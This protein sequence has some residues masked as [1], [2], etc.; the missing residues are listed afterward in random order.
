MKC[1]R[2]FIIGIVLNFL[3]S[4]P[5]YAQHYLGGLAGLSLADLDMSVHA[6]ARTAF[7]LGAMYDFDFSDRFALHIEAMYLQKGGSIDFPDPGPDAKL[8]SDYFELPFL[9]KISS[10][11]GDIRPYFEMGPSFGLL[12]ASSIEAEI[13]GETYSATIQ[14]ITSGLDVG[15]TAGGGIDYYL[16]N[17]KL[18]I[19]ARYTY[20]AN[21]MRVHGTA[22]L[23]GG[24]QSEIINFADDYYKNKCLQV[25][26]GISF[27]LNTD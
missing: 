12:L 19:Q 17:K 14:E 8:K 6:D 13:D 7:G 26:A 27:L 3:W 4:I 16:G 21:R 5:V 1:I 11:G 18:F 10:F 15:F 24:G 25:M 2:W 9:I 20:S 23:E 22:Q